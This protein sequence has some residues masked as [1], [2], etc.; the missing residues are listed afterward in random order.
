LASYGYTSDSIHGRKPGRQ[1][2]EPVRQIAKWS[3]FA[4]GID[5]HNTYLAFASRPQ[6]NEEI[7]LGSGWKLDLK[8]ERWSKV[9]QV[10]AQS[11]DGQTARKRDLREKLGYFK[12]LGIP[13]SKEEAKELS[14]SIP[15]FKSRITKMTSLLT[16]TMADLARELRNLVQVTDEV[17]DMKVFDGQT[18]GDFYKAAFL[19]GYLMRDE[20]RKILFVYGVG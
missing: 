13:A 7:R 15:D 11:M 14:A 12:K 16:N 4:I 19:T 10:L 8:G 5:E 9:L 1:I 3:D 18:N 6:L 17:H 2:V 20:N